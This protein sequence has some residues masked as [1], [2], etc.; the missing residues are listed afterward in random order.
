MHVIMA[1]NIISVELLC[2]ACVCICGV[3]AGVPTMPDAANFY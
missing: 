1:H 3:T 2:G